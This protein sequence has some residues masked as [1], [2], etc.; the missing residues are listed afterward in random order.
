LQKNGAEFGKECIHAMD[1]ENKM[2]Y[3]TLVKQ[4]GVV[5]NKVA[6]LSKDVNQLLRMSDMVV[7]NQ[8]RV[9]IEA[10]R[11]DT[12]IFKVRMVYTLDMSCHALFPICQKLFI[13]L[14]C[15]LPE[16]DQ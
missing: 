9:K 1:D 10:E 8:K 4:I 5:K 7:L 11:L 3:T 16:D 15:A 6:E 14:C 2:R 13:F 12:I